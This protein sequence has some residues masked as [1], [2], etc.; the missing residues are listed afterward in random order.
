MFA[1]LRFELRHALR[2]LL[3]SPG[4][5][6]AALITLAL[7]TGA[8]AAIFSVVH[9]VL[10]EPLPFAEP[11]RMV[12]VWL[13]NPQQGFEKDIASYPNFRDWREQGTSF[14]QMVGVTGVWGRSWAAAS[15]TRNTRPVATR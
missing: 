3:K 1:E 11:D 9:S 12:T 6:A 5:T 15:G 14:S 13:N 10:L 2:G 7:G 8:N 4:F